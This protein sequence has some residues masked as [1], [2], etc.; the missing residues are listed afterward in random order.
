MSENLLTYELASIA[1]VRTMTN[2]GLFGEC[3]KTPKEGNRE[4]KIWQRQTD[5]YPRSAAVVW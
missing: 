3:P 4:E 1:F 5:V 2:T